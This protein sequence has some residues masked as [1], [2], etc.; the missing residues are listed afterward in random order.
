MKIHEMMKYAV[1]NRAS[2]LHIKVGS[3]AIIRV[4][5]ELIEID[6]QQL[7][8]K[9]TEELTLE[10]LGPE[11]FRVLDREGEIDF[12]YSEKG[13]G[14]FRVNAY[15]QR[16]TYGIALRVVNFE[17]PTLKELGIPE[18]IG[19]FTDLTHGLILVTGPTGS[20]KSTTLASMIQ[21]INEKRRCH[22]IT[23][24]DPIEY[25]YKNKKAIIGQREIGI[26]TTSFSKGLR[27]SL[28]QDP[29]VIL[30][31]E[32]RDIET[33]EIALLAA[34]TGHLVLST[35][36]TLGA[37]KT[38]DRIIDSFPN[39]TK[40][41]IKVQLA[42][43]I[44]GVISQQLLPNKSGHGRVPACEIMVANTGIR[45]MIRESKSHQ[46]QNAIVTGLGQGMIT[47]DNS[48]KNLYQRGIISRE[49]AINHAIER[50]ELIKGIEF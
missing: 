33:I 3:P 44:Q 12:S 5:G 16:N 35:L 4:D 38:V 18:T 43:V 23:L 46:I 34:E 7:Y 20:G 48:L 31:G 24:E 27:A 49:A 29:D 50:E 28:R 15:K 47:M 19:S 30:V 42:S 6:S 41:Q 10:I 13:I 21:M 1:D 45:N 39:N 11:R 32:M 8:P 40:D 9:D 26:D 37:A 25:L 2:D 17:I 14:R 36:H 22:I